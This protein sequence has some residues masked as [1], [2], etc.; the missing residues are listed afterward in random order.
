MLLHDAIKKHRRSRRRTKNWISDIVTAWAFALRDE[1]GRHWKVE[2]SGPFGLS[3]VAWITLTYRGKEKSVAFVHLSDKDVLG[4]RDWSKD[5]G[6]FAPGTI[7]DMNG[8]NFPTVRI[9]QDA[10]IQWLRKWVK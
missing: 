8:L 2:V 4:V 6:E 5:S 9:P 10:D 7:G 3:C 1:M